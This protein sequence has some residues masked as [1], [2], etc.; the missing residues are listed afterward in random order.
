MPPL[1]TRKE[2]VPN[3]REEGGRR[4]EEGR[5]AREAHVREEEEG[6]EGQRWEKVASRR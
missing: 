4:K 6:W 5:Q 3:E 1:R 2:R